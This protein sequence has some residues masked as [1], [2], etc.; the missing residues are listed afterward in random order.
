[1]K[2]SNILTEMGIN[3]SCHNEK[4]FTSLG[5]AG[6]NNGDAVC[7]FLENIKYADGMSECITMILTNDTTAKQLEYNMKDYGICIVDDPRNVFFLLHN[8]LVKEKEE[9]LPKK[10]DTVIGENCAI[11]ELA[12]ISKHN[13]T[14]GNN[15]V[16]EPFAVISDNTVIGDNCIIRAGAHIGCVGFEYKRYNGAIFGVEHV[17]GVRLGN[18]VEIQD[19]CCINRAIYPWDNT[20]VGDYSKLDDTVHLGHGVKIGKRTMVVTHVSIGGRTKVGDDAW[21]GIGAIVRNAITIGD[22]ARVNMGAV[23]SKPVADDESVTGNFAIEHSKFISNMK[24]STL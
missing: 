20:V 10:Y 23:V 3:H 14:I 7:T 2:L 9:Y 13:V 24:K 17:G 8:Y 12:S 22:R 18:S 21:I 6:Y 1:M 5:L 16:I 4:D 11:S 19:N 15:C